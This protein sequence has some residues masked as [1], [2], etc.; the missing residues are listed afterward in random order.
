[1]PKQEDA[2]LLETEIGKLKTIIETT[3][4]CKILEY[5]FLTTTGDETHCL[6]FSASASENEDPTSFD[7]HFGDNFRLEKRLLPEI[8]FR[9]NYLLEYHVEKII[10]AWWSKIHENTHR[11]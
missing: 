1:M 9:R 10:Y 2:I 3:H 11:L 8:T 7:L 6:R 4:K 5:A